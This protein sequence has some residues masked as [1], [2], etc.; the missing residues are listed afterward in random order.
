MHLSIVLLVSVEKELLAMI[1]TSYLSVVGNHLGKSASDGISIS[2]QPAAGE[3]Y[4]YRPEGDRDLLKKN[5]TQLGTGEMCRGVFINMLISGGGS[6]YYLDR[7]QVLYRTPRVS[8]IARLHRICDC[9]V[10]PPYLV[11]LPELRASDQSKLF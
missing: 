8:S 7:P 6:P 11:S 5:R 9:T 4:V 2:R 3:R 1:V 10:N